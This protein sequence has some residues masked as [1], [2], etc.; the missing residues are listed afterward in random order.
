MAYALTG[1][2]WP[3]AVVTWSLAPPAAATDGYP[4]LT[5]PL[6]DAREQAQ[7][8]DAL[9]DWSEI[10]GLSFVQVPDNG[11]ATPDIR[12]GFFDTTNGGRD[13]SGDRSV[14]YSYWRYEG[15]TLLPGVLVVAQDLAYWPWST[16]PDGEILYSG[17]FT[18]RQVL[19]HEVG[20]A[21]GLNHSDTPDDLMYARTGSANRSLSPDDVA[22]ARALYGTPYDGEA[23]LP[24]G[25]AAGPGGV[26]QGA[27]V[28]FSA[29][30]Y[31]AAQPDVAAAGMNPRMHFE[32]TGWREDRDPSADF[33]L[34]HYLA[35]NPDV[36]AAG[37]NPFTHYLLHGREE[38]RQAAAA[39]G[40]VAEDGF[41]AAYY[42]LAN[43]D[44]AGSGGDARAHYTAFGWREGRD[45]NGY[46]DASAYLAN[47]ADVAAADMDPL[48]HYMA[49]GWRE[50]RGGNPDFNGAAYLAA[51]PDVAA[52]GVNPLLHYM[53]FGLYEGRAAGAEWGA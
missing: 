48:Q 10:S 53:L 45:P 29:A 33:D 13:L 35:R 16:S 19:A 40:T 12:I 32:A 15:G 14:G 37:N 30:G 50:G 21:I 34:R 42:L 9:A 49:H 28:Q 52:G 1:Q 26:A 25:I 31:L 51:N 44:L 43:P 27:A 20:H 3:D 41:D 38:G 23:P 17:G 18:L 39:V 8:H 11:A 6:D 36:A 4:A 2:R 22:G 47:N 46:F 24:P 7:L 5:A